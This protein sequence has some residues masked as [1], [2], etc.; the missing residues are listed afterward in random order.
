LLG[1]A[2]GNP[3]GPV[4]HFEFIAGWRGSG[5]FEGLEFR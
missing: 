1:D 5:E 2:A 4:A 3:D